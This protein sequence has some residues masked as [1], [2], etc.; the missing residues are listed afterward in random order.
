[1]PRLSFTTLCASSNDIITIPAKIK[2]GAAETFKTKYL[3]DNRDKQYLNLVL[4]FG[5]IDYSGSLDDMSLAFYTWGTSG[6][7]PVHHVSVPGAGYGNI[8]GSFASSFMDIIKTGAKVTDINYEEENNVVISYTED[9]GVTT[10]TARTVLVTAS[11]GVLK[12]GTISFTPSLPDWKQD[13][14]D[15]MGF[16]V[17]NKC[18]LQWDDPD[19][20]VWP[21]EAGGFELITPDDETSGRWTTFYNPSKTKGV[22]FLTA[23]IGG[24]DAMAVEEQTDEEILNEVMANL[25]AMFPTAT[26]PDKYIITRWGKEENVRGAYSFKILGRDFD[27]DAESLRWPLDNSVWFAGEA[28]SP[29][30]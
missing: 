27:D 17:T 6:G 13:A 30:W 28:T 19:A 20:M 18:I 22:P 14:I 16:G 1:M 10:V 26:D 9:G 15:G 29:V 25:R 12:S 5:T 24:D 7:F 11:L 3:E 23:F 2:T 21:E 4:D 8:A